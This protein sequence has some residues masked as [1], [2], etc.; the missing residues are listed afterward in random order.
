MPSVV[1][2]HNDPPGRLAGNE[3]PERGADVL[4][5]YGDF[6]LLRDEGGDRLD[7]ELNQAGQDPEDQ[8]RPQPQADWSRLQFSR[9]R[10]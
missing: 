7:G 9:P 4:R 2:F 6:D 8:P 1:G 3:E 5:E 10:S